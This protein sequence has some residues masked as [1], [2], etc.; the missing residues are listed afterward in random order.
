[1]IL[2]K[3]DSKFRIKLPL[4]AVPYFSGGWAYFRYFPEVQKL[5]IGNEEYIRAIKRNIEER[6]GPLKFSNQSAG[7]AARR[8]GSAM[9][10]SVVQGNGRLIIPEQIRVF[11]DFHEGDRLEFIAENGKIAF[12]KIMSSAV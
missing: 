11:A 12:R 1:M 3:I 8:V 9:A 2:R 5:E 4:E 10:S 6:Y 7:D